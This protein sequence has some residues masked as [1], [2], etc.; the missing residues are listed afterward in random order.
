M[1][2]VLQLEQLEPVLTQVPHGA[3]HWMQLV[4]EP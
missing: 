3:V 1:L 4:P 2:P